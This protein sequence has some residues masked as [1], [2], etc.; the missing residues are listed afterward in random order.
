VKEVVVANLAVERA[1]AE[2]AALARRSPA[3]RD[4]RLTA[5]LDDLAA[6]MEPIRSRLLH[7]PSLGRR[8]FEPELRAASAALQLERRRV[9]EMLR[10]KHGAR[11]ASR[12]APYS[13]R[14][15]E[16]AL[17]R[18][19]GIVK[20][21]E[22]TAANLLGQ[23]LPAGAS[24]PAVAKRREMATEMREDVRTTRLAILERERR[25][26]AASMAKHGRLTG[27]VEEDLLRAEALRGR[28]DTL[29][30]RL[31]RAERC[32]ARPAPRTTRPRRRKWR[33]WTVEDALG[34][35]A[36]WEDE[37]GRPARA[38]DLTDPSLPSF[39]TVHRLFGGMIN[40]DSPWYSDKR[41]KLARRSHRATTEDQ[42]LSRSR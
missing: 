32:K 22:Q 41:Y 18:Y 36:A 27:S 31:Y 8:G 39:G 11:R 40:E 30:R 35:L 28:L 13:A 2:R 3:D 21:L 15:F 42:A 6:A 25:I 17:N 29:D 34:E 33:R 9:R 7:A 1:A 10:R 38:R 14:S 20:G 26:V 24:W 16:Q 23:R 5:V 19:S 12:V 37:H 4:E